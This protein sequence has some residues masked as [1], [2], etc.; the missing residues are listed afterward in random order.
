M[1]DEN[2][3]SELSDGQAQRLGSITQPVKQQL[4]QKTVEETVDSAIAVTKSRVDRFLSTGSSHLHQTIDSLQDLKSEYDVYEDI[5]FGKIKEGV[6]V[7]ASHPMASCSAAVGLGFLALKRPRRFL[8]Y[9]TLRLFTSEESLLSRA[10]N[11]VK[12]LRQS[13]DLLKAES[14]KLEKSALQAEGELIRGRTKL[15]QAGKQ[16][17]S[18]IRSAYKIE[19][20][21]WGLKD[22]LGELPRREAS[23]FRSQVSNLASEAK[24]ERSAMTKEVSK[25]SNYGISV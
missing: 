7:A 18:V 11:K 19:R 9:N 15:R 23:R 12:E 10:D 24:K 16:I 3:S 25:I 20:Q 21:A 1:R 17:Q 4:A 2:R 8:Y 6:L 22:D 5:V 13:I 14:E